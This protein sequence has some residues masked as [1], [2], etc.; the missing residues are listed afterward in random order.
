VNS[1][2]TLWFDYIINFIDECNTPAKMNELCSKDRMKES[3]I[4]VDKVNKCVKDS[5][6]TKDGQVV[7]NKLLAEDRR[8]S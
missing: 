2:F 8:W 4:D 3:L 6:V 1:N 5:Y 7:D